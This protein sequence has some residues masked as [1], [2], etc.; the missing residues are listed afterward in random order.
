[1]KGFDE[2]QNFI[3]LG[4]EKVNLVGTVANFQIVMPDGGIEQ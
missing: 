4:L 3:F 1:M 2:F